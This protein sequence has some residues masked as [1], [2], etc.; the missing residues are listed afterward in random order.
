MVATVSVAMVGAAW[1]VQPGVSYDASGL[2]ALTAVFVG[3]SLLCMIWG[4]VRCCTC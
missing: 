1:Q 3:L 4:E 2:Y